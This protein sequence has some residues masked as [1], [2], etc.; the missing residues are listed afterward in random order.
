M[1]QWAVRPSESEVM[2]WCRVTRVCV[3]VVSGGFVCFLGCSLLVCYFKL[4]KVCICVVGDFAF[5]HYY[6]VLLLHLHA[7]IKAGCGL[8]AL[9]SCMRASNT[10]R[11]GFACIYAGPATMGLT[12]AHPPFLVLL[13][14]DKCQTLCVSLCAIKESL[15]VCV[16]VSVRVCE[17]ERV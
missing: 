17:K 7:T 2:V 4:P 16:C 3:L 12:V 6:V 10:I 5:Y 9:P 15:N 14:S 13:T 8:A 1:L 11:L